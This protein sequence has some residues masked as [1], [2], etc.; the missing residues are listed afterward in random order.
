MHSVP[1]TTGK[2][3]ILVTHHATLGPVRKARGVPASL[4]APPRVGV[5]FC[6][7]RGGLARAEPSAARPRPHRGSAIQGA[8]ICELRQP[9]ISTMD[10]AARTRGCDGR[11][12]PGDR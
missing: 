5:A 1:D 10:I 12:S 3:D 11:A 6:R 8:A 4:V 2:D 9:N 7:V